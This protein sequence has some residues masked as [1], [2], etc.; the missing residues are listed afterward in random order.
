MGGAVSK[1]K[2]I[3]SLLAII[4]SHCENEGINR[5]EIDERLRDACEALYSLSIE[6]SNLKYVESPELKDL[7]LLETLV[8]AFDRNSDKPEICRCLIRTI[9]NLSSAEEN[10]QYMSSN[11]LGLV[12]ILLKFIRQDNSEGRIIACGMIA[13]F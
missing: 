6:D 9:Y 5:K 7:F 8:I 4:H 1:Y 10:H 2:N 13:K 3:K 12:P 11:K